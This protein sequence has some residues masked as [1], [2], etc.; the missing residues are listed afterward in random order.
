VVIRADATRLAGGEGLCDATTGAVPVDEAVGAILAGAYVKAVVH[1]GVDVTA[2]AHL[3]RHIPAE[4]KTAVQERDGQRCVRPGCG[5]TQHLEVHHYRVDYAKGGATA[6]WNLAT[7][8]SHDHDLITHGG[9]RL[10]G[11]PGRWTWVPPP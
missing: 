6:Y 5:A 9:H 3:G 8:C 1:D 2:V 7:V 4:L 10:E 11:G